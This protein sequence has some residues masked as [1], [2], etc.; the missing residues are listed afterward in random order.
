MIF[1]HYMTFMETEIRKSNVKRLRMLSSLYGGIC[2]LTLTSLGPISQFLQQWRVST[3]THWLPEQCLPSH[4]F[5]L[6][7]KALLN[8]GASSN[9]SLMKLFFVITKR[10]QTNSLFGFKSIQRRENIC[11]CVSITSG[12]LI[13]ISMEL[14]LFSLLSD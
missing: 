7:V 2:H 1:P 13:I 12:W 4:S 11:H 8:D 10:I 14:D 5:G 9:L 6:G 3:C